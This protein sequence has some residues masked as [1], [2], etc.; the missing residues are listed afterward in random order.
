MCYINELAF[1]D[2]EKVQL[3]RHLHLQAHHHLYYQ[4]M[5]ILIYIQ[6]ILFYN[7][8]SLYDTKAYGIDNF[9]PKSLNTAQGLYFKQFATYFA[10]VYHD[11]YTTTITGICR[12]SL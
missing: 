10:Y 6:D 8:A 12:E 7:Y 9:S 5:A 3:S 4:A 1:T 11:Q 2:L